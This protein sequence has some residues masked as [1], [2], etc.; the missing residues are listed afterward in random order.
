M[1]LGLTGHRLHGEEN[2]WAGLTNIHSSSGALLAYGA[3]ESC[4]CGCV[5]AVT[6][7]A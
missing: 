5:G 6:H 3:R 2:F 7:L 1:Y 4:V